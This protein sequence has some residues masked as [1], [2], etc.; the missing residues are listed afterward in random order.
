MTLIAVVRVRGRVRASTEVK[1]TMR[2]LNL[3]R[4]NH[5]VLV[6]D[7]PQTLGMVKKVK[8]Y[9]TWGP[10]KLE[11]VEAMLEKRARTQGKQGLTV[12]Y[13]KKNTEYSNVKELGKA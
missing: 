1:E 9:V 7:T 8:D 2:L 12:E 6:Q 13:L 4:V 3:D 11:V 5:C 10:V